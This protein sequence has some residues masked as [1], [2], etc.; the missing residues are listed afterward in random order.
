MTDVARF[1]DADDHQLTTTIERLLENL[2]R[3]DHALIQ[4]AGHPA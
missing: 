3:L 2:N 4:A 1:A